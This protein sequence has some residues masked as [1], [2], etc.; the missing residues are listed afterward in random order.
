[1]DSLPTPPRSAPFVAQLM[2]PVLLATLWSPPASE[3]SAQILPGTEAGAG[4]E[5]EAEEVRT[6]IVLAQEELADAWV[7]ITPLAIGPEP[8]IETF[9]TL[10]D[11]ERRLRPDLPVG[12]ALLC[13]GARDRGIAC[14]TFFHYR[15]PAGDF[16]GEL[17]V[18]AAFFPGR[19]V[20]GEIRQRAFPVERAGVRVVPAGLVSLRPFSLP[21]AP[22]AAGGD[23]QRT[24]T[25]DSFGRFQTPAIAPGTYFLEV[26][27]PSGRLFRGPEFT[28]EGDL[29]EE[30]QLA[31]PPVLAVLEDGQPPAGGPDPSV[32]IEIEV[33]PEPYDL[34]RID[35]DEGL[36]LDVHI[37]DTADNP[38]PGAVVEA[39]QGAHALDLVTFEQLTDSQGE[40][41]LAG[42]SA[43]RP[44]TLRFG[45]PGLRA[46][47]LIFELIPARIYVILEPLATLEG[48]VLVGDA[49]PAVG[50][51]VSLRSIDTTPAAISFPEAS[52]ITALP[53]TESLAPLATLDDGSFR[54]ADLVAGEYELI[55]AAPGRAVFQSSLRIE[56][57]ESLRLDPISL[58]SGREV[59]GRVL[60]KD[61]REGLAGVTISAQAPAGA[62]E[63]ESGADGLFQFLTA[64]DEP[65]QLLFTAEGH[66]EH[67]LHLRPEQLAAD[68][69][70][71]V[72][73][74]RAGWIL[75]TV[76][77]GTEAQ[78][79]CQGCRLFLSPGE[80]PLT[81]DPAGEALSQP[82]APGRYRI[83]R[84]TVRH[85]G[86]TAIEQTDA[87]IR[88]VRVAAGEISTVRLGE[89]RESVSLAFDP[90]WDPGW[91]L[92]LRAPGRSERVLPR[93]DGSFPITRRPGE[94]PRL[95]AR[96]F[97]SVAG[98]DAELYQGDL[99]A[100]ISEDE[101]VIPRHPT[102]VRGQVRV[103]GA[104]R[105][106]L[107]LQLL[108]LRGEVL[109]TFWTG[110]DGSFSASHLPT[111]VYSLKIEERA[112]TFVSLRNGLDLDLGA[113]DLPD[114][115]F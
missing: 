97:D 93:A 112:I 105:S 110:V 52:E 101:L 102:H 53:T 12:P 14:T 56:P 27:L 100:S 40:A 55:A 69:P 66:A 59:V 106:G 39:R 80:R 22:S 7:E 79:P 42:F 99:P 85:L 3:P 57:G 2:V 36:A 75:A 15:G 10:A 76:A 29:D 82:L 49:E 72:E 87:E 96:F 44:V 108:D 19:P 78:T 47:E 74:E 26:H 46:A 21:L 30:P 103:D 6:E 67:V 68:R 17:E 95:F 83:H 38:I 23:L 65:L 114:G 86:S 107:R 58:L 51:R 92:V 18:A 41:R 113:F 111:G 109:G 13:S 84:P 98:R 24:V 91:S 25:T 73:L 33:E 35:I 81:T 11:G 45:A 9:T 70:L 50:A 32:P 20:A 94:T 62:V 43:E 1:M 54:F 63:A 89:P 61:T 16:R 115:S 5:A 77:D 48:E 71:E 37:R 31:E 28:L 4:A 104:P 88:E 60:D 34:G 90:P 8:L 64:S